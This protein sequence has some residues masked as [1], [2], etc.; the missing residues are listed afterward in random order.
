MP[1]TMPGRPKPLE[2]GWVQII[3]CVLFWVFAFSALCCAV[4]S[5]NCVYVFNATDV[6]TAI[7]A[8]DT[9]K[10]PYYK[11]KAIGGGYVS[12]NACAM[13]LGTAI[14]LIGLLV[15]TVVM[16]TSCIVCCH[17]AD[18]G[19]EEIG[20]S[21]VSRDTRCMLDVEMKKVVSTQLT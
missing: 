2:C 16:I 8:I 11:C 6:R 12:Y 18:S 20:P 1:E 15:S 10:A 14:I 17:G 13:Y 21:Y 3:L 9:D 5:A 4:D 19:W 7:C